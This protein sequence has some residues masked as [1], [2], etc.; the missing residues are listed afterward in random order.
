MIMHVLMV[1]LSLDITTYS[2]QKLWNNVTCPAFMT[3]SHNNAT[4]YLKKVT[5]FGDRI[6]WNKDIWR[7]LCLSSR[8]S[9]IEPLLLIIIILVSVLKVTKLFQR[10]QEI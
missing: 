6:C 5:S 8:S 10:K 4:I 7:V 2:T 1:G 3:D 9:K